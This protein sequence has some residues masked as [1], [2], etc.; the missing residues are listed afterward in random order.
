MPCS[1]NGLPTVDDLGDTPLRREQRQLAADAVLQ[2]C[3]M[4]GAVVAYYHRNEEPIF[5]WAIPGGDTVSER[6]DSR[7]VDQ[8]SKKDWIIPYQGWGNILC[9]PGASSGSDPLVG[10]P[11]ANDISVEDFIFANG[12]KYY[13]KEYES[14]PLDAVFT[15]HCE[16]NKNRRRDIK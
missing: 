8:I 12:H 13:V 4:E 7:K 16:R 10:F 5:V 1:P 14:D 2:Q 6:L 11:P 15:L 9:T 3:Q